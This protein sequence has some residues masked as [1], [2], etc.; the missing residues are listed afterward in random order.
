MQIAEQGHIIVELHGMTVPVFQKRRQV[1]MGEWTPLYLLQRQID[2]ET[3]QQRGHLQI[4]T[5]FV[6]LLNYLWTV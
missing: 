3:G 2:K 4:E 1:K 6:V 5:R